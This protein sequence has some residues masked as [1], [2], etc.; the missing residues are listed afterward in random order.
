MNE[1]SDKM[2]VGRK[3]KAEREEIKKQVRRARPR[4]VHTIRHCVYFSHFSSS[5]TRW[6]RVFF[7]CL[8]IIGQFPCVVHS[9]V[10]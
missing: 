3:W 2:E 4:P 8:H 10:A 5:V 9:D 7:N 1:N 6:L